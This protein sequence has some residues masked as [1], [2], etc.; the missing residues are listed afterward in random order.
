[1]LV[2]RLV[3][4]PRSVLSVLVRLVLVAVLVLRLL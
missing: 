1:V 2:L 4:A 3:I